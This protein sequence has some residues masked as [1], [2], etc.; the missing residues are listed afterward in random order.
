MKF[1]AHQ[2]FHLRDTW[3]MKGMHAVGQ[4]GKIFKSD[5]AVEELGVGKNMVESIEYWLNALRLIE[6]DKDNKYSLSEVAKLIL[7]SDSY[8]ELDG[9]NIL[10]HYLLATNSKEATSFF[11]FFNKFAATEF[12]VESLNVYLQ[13]FVQSADKKFNENTLKKDISCLVR[14]Y[15]EPNYE[16]KVN[17]ESENPSPFVKFGL[18][19][20]ENKKLLKHKFKREEVHPLVFVYLMYRF[21]IDVL[22]AAASF[23]LDEVVKK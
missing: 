23:N 20:E 6:K 5:N 15:K 11:W 17:P 19:T 16:D 13:S 1:G 21:W 22:A 4:N 7:A 3:L 10:L 18:I 9:S 8:L 12:D 14:T 2:T